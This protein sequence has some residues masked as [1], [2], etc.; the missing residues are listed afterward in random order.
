MNFFI[1]NNKYIH[2][3]TNSENSSGTKAFIKLSQTQCIQG[4]P[5][6]TP[7]KHCWFSF[8]VEKPDNANTA[9]SWS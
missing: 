4:T 7:P 3:K 6:N 9:F 8:N 1:D 5:Q 2:E